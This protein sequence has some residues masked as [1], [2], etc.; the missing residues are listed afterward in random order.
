MFGFVGET[1]RRLRKERGKTLEQLGE[2]AGLGRG[3]LSRIENARQEATLTTLDKILTSQGVSRRDFFHR[4]DLVE[5]EAAAVER[6]A[7]GAPDGQTGHSGQPGAAPGDSGAWPE[8]I[9]EVLGKLESFVSM[10]FRQPHPV[11][12][13]VVELGD[14]VVLFRVVS[15]SSA[16]TAAPAPGAPP[17]SG[18]AV[19]TSPRRRGA[20]KKKR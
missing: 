15:R 19:P 9:R 5:G 4:Y 14:L 11:A 2:E 17:P 10:T 18:T 6:A 7:A 1:L 3:Q 8:E 16:E 20:G 12:Q 13:G